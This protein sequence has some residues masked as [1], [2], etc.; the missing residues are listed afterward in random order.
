[1]LRVYRK[2]RVTSKQEEDEKSLF[3]KQRAREPIIVKSN[4]VGKLLEV[5]D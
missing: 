1:M 5:S 4:E 2:L 3:K